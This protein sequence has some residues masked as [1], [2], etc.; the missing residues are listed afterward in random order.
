M[1]RKWEIPAACKTGHYP[2]DGEPMLLN[3]LALP[4]RADMT[5]RA[6]QTPAR[7]Q[8]RREQGELSSAGVTHELQVSAR[9]GAGTTAGTRE[10]AAVAGLAR[11]AGRGARRGHQTAPSG[12]WPLPRASRQR[13]WHA[14][15]TCRVRAPLPAPIAHPPI[16]I[17]SLCAVDRPTY[18][19]ERGPNRRPANDS[20][21]PSK[22]R[23]PSK[24]PPSHIL[25]WALGQN[26]LL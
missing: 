20:Q 10:V 8:S 16:T 3:V 11:I 24:V 22:A 18:Q 26:A 1:T 15:T 25:S 21:H 19:K 6:R 2:L 17:G 13:D 5:M 4:V 9:R 14:C 23:S 7:G 12:T